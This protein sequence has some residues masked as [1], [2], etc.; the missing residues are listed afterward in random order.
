MR[1]LGAIIVVLVGLLGLWFDAAPANAQGAADTTGSLPPASA[2]PRTSA[3]PP[4][5]AAKPGL[6]ESYAVIPLAERMAAQADLIWSGHYTGPINGEFSDAFVTAVKAFQ[7]QNKSKQTG[8]LNPAERQAL[9]ELVRP[10][11]EQVG[12]RMVQDSVTG[13]RLGVPSKLAPIASVSKTGGMWSSQQGQVRIETFRII[14]PDTPLADIFE[15]MKHEPSE[16]KV[17]QHALRPDS[18]ALIGMQG[19]KKFHVRAYARNGEVRGITILYDQAV[20]GTMDP[21]VGPLAHSYQP[22]VNM[23]DAAQDTTA[24]KRRIE[25]GTGLVVSSAG[26]IVTDLQI[27]EACQVVTIPGLGHAERLAADSDNNL[28][29]LRVY[30]AEDLVPLALLGDAPKG[31]DLIVIGIADPQSQA[32]NAAISIANVKLVS[33]AS[34][35]GTMNTLNQTPAIGFSGAAALDKN[36]RVFGMVALKVP[37][38]AGAGTAAAPKATVVPVETIRTF[39]EANYVA[40][41]SGQG[42]VENAKASVVRVICVRK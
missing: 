9:I 13:A 38:V 39:I 26:H 36:G 6:K 12:W 25:Y 32:G 21:L 1:L 11:Q 30:G 34:T 5:A 37:V 16:R 24:L 23:A 41:T 15:R 42:G 35:S 14:A 29:L 40:P 18:F 19:L 7:R 3:V 17:E 8:V 2:A 4:S 31:P 33:T 28:A 27:V 20:D 22:F 10:L